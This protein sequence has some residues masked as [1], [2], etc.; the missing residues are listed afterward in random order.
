MV[1]SYDIEK[2]IGSCPSEGDT[3]RNSVAAWFKADA[4]VA[5]EAPIPEGPL[6]ATDE[7][8]KEPIAF[9]CFLLAFSMQ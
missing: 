5:L 6:L 4:F 9:S 1:G 3:E 2:L 8:A 7:C